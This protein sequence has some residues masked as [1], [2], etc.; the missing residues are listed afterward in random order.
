MTG[1]TV[2]DASSWEQEARERLER[3]GFD[4]FSPVEA[5]TSKLPDDHVISP[6]SNRIKHPFG[7]REVFF[8]LDHNEVKRAD[9]VY[10]NVT[11]LKG[12]NDMSMGTDWELSWAYE[13][14]HMIVLVTRP[15]QVYAQH[16]FIKASGIL[17][18]N[19]QEEALKFLE[20]YASSGWFRRGKPGDPCRT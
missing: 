20:D 11:P 8:H 6:G 9:I 7:R 3:A 18:F 16:P 13:F 19:K 10:A 14:D 2:K 1:L 4:C 15:E 17:V 12:N 5:E